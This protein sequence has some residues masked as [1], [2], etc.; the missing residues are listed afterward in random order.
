MSILDV[1]SE[2]PVIRIRIRPITFLER[3]KWMVL[4]FTAV[5]TLEVVVF[6]PVDLWPLAWPLF[7]LIVPPSALVA[8]LIEHGVMRFLRARLEKEDA[9]A[10]N[11]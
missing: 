9:P 1:V 8:S 11:S 5:V 2:R 3:F 6:A 10:P 7:M 4:F